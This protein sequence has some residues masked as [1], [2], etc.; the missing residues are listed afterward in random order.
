MTDV[1]CV[2]P[3]QQRNITTL[4]WW[5]LRN[6]LCK[7]VVC[8]Q[9]FLNQLHCFSCSVVCVQLFVLMLSSH[10][11]PSAFHKNSLMFVVQCFVSSI[12]CFSPLLL[13]LPPSASYTRCTSTCNIMCTR[14][15]LHTHTPL[16]CH[17][18]G[19]LISSYL[20]VFAPSF[21]AFNSPFYPPF[22]CS[23]HR[24]LTQQNLASSLL[25]PECKSWNVI[26]LFD[27][28]Q[29]TLLWRPKAKH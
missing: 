25:L 9:C 24:D 28:Y 17:L 2:I 12:P 5:M 18:A 14:A 19:S 20:V 7:Q 27:F 23:L 1:A 13:S 11:S 16:A 26:N 4:G 15:C 6:G 8:A 22:S 29:V 3:N 10:V 21:S